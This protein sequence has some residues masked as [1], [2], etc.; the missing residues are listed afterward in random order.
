MSKPAQS[1]QSKAVEK[2]PSQN[3][4]PSGELVLGFEKY[5][6][7]KFVADPH[8]RPLSNRFPQIKKLIE[9]AYFTGASVVVQGEHECKICGQN[10]CYTLREQDKRYLKSKEGV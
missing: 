10:T 9:D 2:A 3:F 6:N 8:A 5:W 4:K 1:P 7:K